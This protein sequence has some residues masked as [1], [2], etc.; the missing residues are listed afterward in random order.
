MA[1]A[2]R[3]AESAELVAIASRSPERAAG[4]AARH[5]VPRSYDSA[6]DLAADPEVDCVYVATEVDRHLEDVVTVARHGRDVLVEKPIARNAIEAARMVDACE[7]AGVRLGVCFYKRFN[8]RHRRAKALIDEGAIGTVAAVSTDYTGR[9]PGT[10]K[11]WRQ[12]LQRS[13]GG[14]FI[15]GGSHV[16]DLLRFFLGAEVAEVTAMMGDAI[17]HTSVED[18]AFAILRFDSG[19]LASIA[20][21]WSVTD[22]SDRRTNVMRIGGTDG[23]LEFWP[24]YEK[25]SRGTLLLADAAGE[26][27]ISVPEGSTHVALLDA[28]ALARANDQ[29]FPITGEDGLIAARVIDAAYGSARTGRAVRP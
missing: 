21:H 24:L 12:D 5:G 16:V 28:I 3:E 27:E 10:R 26:R 2:M 4:F 11:A 18:T 19:V 22:P 1:P 15:D 17:D 29:P 25:H 14:P 13:G 20:A 7:R 23:S 8:T 9:L 6:D